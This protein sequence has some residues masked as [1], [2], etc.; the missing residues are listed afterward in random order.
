MTIVSILEIQNH[1][2]EYLEQY[3]LT[4]KTNSPLLPSYSG[5]NTFCNPSR[6][7]HWS[8]Y[9]RC[10][11]LSF[12]IQ[13]DFV[14]ATSMVLRMWHSS[15]GSSPIPHGWSLTR[16]IQ[17]TSSS[18]HD[19]TRHGI[20]YNYR[21][22]MSLMRLCCSAIMVWVAFYMLLS[23]E[24]VLS[25]R[26]CHEN[27]L[28]WSRW[29]EDWCSED[30]AYELSHMGFYDSGNCC[31]CWSVYKCSFLNVLALPTYLHADTFTS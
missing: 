3:L 6:C 27:L 8:S 26:S 18:M 2:F 14:G 5:A 1:L 15:R 30:T 13:L 12:G 31:G 28:V 23:N 7:N 24:L 25:F 11:S 19:D 10:M 22:D 29:N 21:V 16:F 20:E 4:N 17:M 9:K